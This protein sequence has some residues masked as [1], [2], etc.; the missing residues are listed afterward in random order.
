VLGQIA[1][2]LPDV[3]VIELGLVA[4]LDLDLLRHLAASV[5]SVAFKDSEDGLEAALFSLEAALQGLDHISMGRRVRE[6]HVK[7]GRVSGAG[8]DQAMLPAPELHAALV[9]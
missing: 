3:H 6:V 7:R 9:V 1:L 4:G 2:V 5:Y 8:L